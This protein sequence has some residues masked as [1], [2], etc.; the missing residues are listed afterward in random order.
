MSFILK[1]RNGRKTIKIYF[2]IFFCSRAYVTL[3]LNFGL[4]FEIQITLTSSPWRFRTIKFQFCSNV[5]D[6][7]ILLYLDLGNKDY[8]DP[9]A[10]NEI[11]FAFFIEFVAEI[12]LVTRFS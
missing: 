5:A 6:G 10:E 3:V 1:S 12:R 11:N 2:Y 7:E 9:N 4:S 8:C